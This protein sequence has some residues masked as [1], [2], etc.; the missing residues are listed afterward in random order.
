MN[1]S[2]RINDMLMYFN[3]KSYFNLKD[4]MEKYS[5]SR[6]TALRDI[7]VLEK[8]GLPV[9]SEKGRNGG[10]RILSKRVLDPIIFTINEIY[11]L[12]FC[13]LTLRGY[14]TTPF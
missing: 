3:K 10:Y 12:Y 11:A 13:M 5:I 9:Y 7:E 1:K 6:S 2:E 8:L 14:E 4:I